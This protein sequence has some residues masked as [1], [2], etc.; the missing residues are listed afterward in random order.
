MNFYPH[1]ARADYNKR[2]GQYIPMWKKVARLY[3]GVKISQ[4]DL[5]TGNF[6]QYSPAYVTTNED[7]RFIMRELQ[8]LDKSVLTVTASGDQ[9]IAFAISGARE[10]DTFDTSYFAKVIMDMKTSAI[11]TINRNQYD[12]FIHA[13]YNNNNV[14]DIP[15][16]ENIVSK[17]PKSSVL[18]ARQMRGCYIFHQGTGIHPEYMPT[19]VEYDAA[20]KTLKKTMNFIWANLSELHTKLNKKYDII[21]LSNIFEY[22]HNSN[23]ITNVLN[24]LEPFLCDDGKIMLYT[25]WVQ[26]HMFELIDAAARKCDWGKTELHTTQNAAMLAMTHAR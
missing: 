21:Y 15:N 17:C 10:I 3:P 18:A 2:T 16:Y 26:T 5:D 19:D 23:K 6:G 13:L 14:Y 9:P 25:S 1:F 22:W 12:D 20:R 7:W 24:E 4:I 8:P 11:Q